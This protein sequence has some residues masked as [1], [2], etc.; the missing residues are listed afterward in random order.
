MALKLIRLL[1]LHIDTKRWIFDDGSNTLAFGHFTV[2]YFKV[3]GG[4]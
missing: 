2:D 3:E 1:C 4:S